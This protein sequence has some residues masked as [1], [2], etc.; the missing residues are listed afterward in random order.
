MI[1]G[2]PCPAGFAYVRWSFVIKLTYHDCCCVLYLS[3]GRVQ[4]SIRRSGSPQHMQP[5]PPFVLVTPPTSRHFNYAGCLNLIEP[6]I[7]V[8]P[9]LEKIQ[10]LW[11]G[12]LVCVLQLDFSPNPHQR[13]KVTGECLGLLNGH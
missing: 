12:I 7:L 3:A 4:G 9:W 8:R 11:T 10:V 6:T 13:V 1:P 5:Q 2:D